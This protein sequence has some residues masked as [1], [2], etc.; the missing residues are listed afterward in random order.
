M[1]IITKPV[2]LSAGQDAKSADINNIADTIYNDYNGNITNANIAAGA[3]IVGSKLDLTAPGG[4]GTVTS[5]SAYFSTLFAS[6]LTIN[7]ISTMVLNNTLTG[8]G[9]FINQT[10]VLG[11]D[12]AAL[13]VSSNAIQTNSSLVQFISVNTASTDQ[14]LGVTNYGSGRIATFNQTSVTAASNE[15][16]RVYSASAQTSSALALFHLDNASST[17]AVDEHRNDGSG[18]NILL[19][20]NGNG[21]HLRF[22]GDP[23]PSSPN[24]G[25]F[26]F[27]GARLLLRI[28]TSTY[29]ISTGAAL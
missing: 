14:V 4:I 29:P 7:T 28:G 20:N 1:A 23:S 19:E 3:A 18:P 13:L 5:G 17:Q 9:L 27:D 24:D 26:W 22:S 8:N 16:F 21:P 15:S 11:L 6:A 10:G 2:T 12:K 25:D